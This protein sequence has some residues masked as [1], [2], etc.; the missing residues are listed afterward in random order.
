MNKKPSSKALYEFYKELEA[1]DIENHGLLIMHG[2]DVVYEKYAYPYSADMPHT[3]F[4]V[5]KSVV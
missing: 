2:Q 4:S 1:H 3:L 5:T